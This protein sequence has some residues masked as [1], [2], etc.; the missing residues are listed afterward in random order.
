MR[1]GKLTSKEVDSILAGRNPKR[2]HGDGGGLWL[3][4]GSR[5]PNG[6]PQAASWVF[7]YM[8]DGK[9]REMGL[10]SAWDVSLADAR[11]TARTARQRVKIGKADVLA[12]RREQARDRRERA[13]IAAARQVTFRECAEALIASKERSWRN[14]V[15]R[16]QWRATLE[17]YA[18]PIIGDLPV[19]EIDTTLVVKVIEPIWM[20]KTETASRLRGRIEAALDWARVR[21]YRSGDNPA[22]WRG[23]VEHLLPRRSKVAPV[24]HHAALPFSD[25]GA[26]FAE[27][28]Q[29]K[30]VAARALE[31]LILTWGR[32]GEVIGCRWAEI[33]TVE[34]LWVL[35]PE[36]MKANR[37]HRVPLSRRAIAIIG[38]MQEIR[39]R[40]PSEYVFPGNKVDEPLSNM[41]LLMTLRRMGHNH[42]TCHGFRATAKTWADEST[43]FPNEMVELA[44]AHEVGD[45][46]EAA[47]RRGSMFEK[48]RRMAEA[49][50]RYCDTPAQ[51]RGNLLAITAA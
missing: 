20:T 17:Q 27:L 11:E 26:F 50:A 42:L 9:N 7:R 6:R 34:R 23:H 43:N 14:T 35:P 21:G 4:V 36:R 10:G 47:Y 19:A 46:T 32:T 44:L 49:W 38:E 1:T 28:R 37:E 48:R 5:D 12:E 30:G 29:Q 18:Y 39:S 22:R 51:E 33:D 40:R 16:Y 45:K 3:I 15:H 31:F 24:E 41:S 13:R 2:Y 25:V 8:L